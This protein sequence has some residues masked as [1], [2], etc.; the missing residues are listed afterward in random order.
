MLRDTFAV[1]PPLVGRAARQV[2]L[3]IHY[4]SVEIT[5]K[6]YASSVKARQE[7]LEAAVIKNVEERLA[8][9]VVSA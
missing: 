9:T 1:E 6:R 2:S 8:L 5:E 3:R 7:Q 4:S